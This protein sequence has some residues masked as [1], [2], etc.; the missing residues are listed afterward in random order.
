[1]ELILLL[2]S[3]YGYLLWPVIKHTEQLLI[4]VIKNHERHKTAQ[5]HSMQCLQKQ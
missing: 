4:A 2:M 5:F 1:M 3:G